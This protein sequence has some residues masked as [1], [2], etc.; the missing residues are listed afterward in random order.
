MI[1][2]EKI[3]RLENEIEKIKPDKTR[4]FTAIER[5]GLFYYNEKPYKTIKGLKK[6]EGIKDYQTLIIVK[7]Y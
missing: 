4:L 1:T 7:H 6:G 3:K 2:R 5:K